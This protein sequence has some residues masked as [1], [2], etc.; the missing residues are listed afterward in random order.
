LGVNLKHPVICRY[1][2]QETYKFADVPHPLQN[3]WGS[4]DCQ[5]RCQNQPADFMEDA[6]GGEDRLWS[7]PD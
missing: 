6:V 5:E 7:L 1:G 4:L 2:Q 3:I